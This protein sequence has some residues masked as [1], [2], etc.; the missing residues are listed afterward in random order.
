M[1]VALESRSFES[2][3]G[4]TICFRENGVGRPIV[5]V[6]G[7]FAGG[8]YFDP[9]LAD[10]SETARVVVMDPRGQGSSESTAR[11]RWLGRAA[12]DIEELLDHVGLEEDVLLVGWSLGV[13]SVLAYADLFGAERLAGLCLVAGAPRLLNGPDW[14]LGFLTL[15]GAVEYCDSIRD[16][17]AGTIRPVVPRLFHVAPGNEEE[18][19]AHTLEAGTPEGEAA[20]VWSGI[21]TDLR[22]ALARLEAPVLA[23]FGR[24]DPLVP[25]GNADVFRQAAAGARAEVFEDCGHSPFLEQPRRFN[26]LLSEFRAEIAA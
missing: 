25:A 9:Q 22:P 15:E 12:F 8:R 10:L 23:V 24:H 1:A 6:P 13:T 2:S 5:F 14:D 20:M 26:R 18:L 7:A 19:L 3:D 16:D 21:T 17:L 11:G 4:V